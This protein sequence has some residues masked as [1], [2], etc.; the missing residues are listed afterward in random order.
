MKPIIS[1]ICF[2]FIFS[3]QSGPRKEELK[4]DAGIV[5]ERFTVYAGTQESKENLFY[6]KFDDQGRPLET[7]E[8]KEGKM[9]GQRKIFD[10][11]V[12]NSVET[13]KNDLFDGPYVSYFP[14]G[15]KQ[16]EGTYKKDVLSGDVSVYYQSGAIKEIVKFQDN[17]ENGPFKE[18]YENGKIKAEGNYIYKDGA[19]EH[20]LLSLYDS[21][22]MLIRKMD[23]KEG[24]C[25]TIWKLEGLNQ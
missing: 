7:I 23:C 15:N 5:L 8:Y 9:N 18:F 24:I 16:M 1:F 17:V 13:R 14:N 25:Q 4:S 19:V 12:L 20:G 21:T 11:G 2:F 10:G 6:E 3:C 22:G